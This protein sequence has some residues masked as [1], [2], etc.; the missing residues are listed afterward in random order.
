MSERNT[1]AR[2]QPMTGEEMFDETASLERMFKIF[3]KIAGYPEDLKYDVDVRAVVE[4]LTRVDKRT[5]YYS[6]FHNGNKI[7]ELK[8]IGILIHWLLKFKPFRITDDRILNSDIEKREEAFKLNESFAVSLIYS[9]LMKFGKLKTTPKKDSEIHKT[10][11]Y[12]FKYRE[13]SQ[14]SVMTLVYSLYNIS[15]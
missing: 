2:Y 4:I 13:M 5:A 12:A 14:D 3:L 10:L 9:G 15:I 1:G 6:Y 8:R 11:I 7:H